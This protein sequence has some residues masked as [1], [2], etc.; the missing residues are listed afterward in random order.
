VTREKKRQGTPS[1]HCQ[2][3]EH[4]AQE[5]ERVKVLQLL[6]RS[7]CSQHLDPLLFTLESC[8]PKVLPCKIYSAVV[9]VMQASTTASTRTSKG[10]PSC[11]GSI[12]MCQQRGCYTCR[13]PA[14]TVTTAPAS[15]AAVNNKQGAV[16]SPR[17]PATAAAALAPAA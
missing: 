15:T 6:R 2:C 5:N 16:T 1:I 9:A 13:N 14:L 4:D 12:C 17:L 11:V 3:A 10:P 8:M 7:F